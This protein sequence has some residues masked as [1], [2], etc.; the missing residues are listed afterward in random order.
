MIENIKKEKQ[1]F[2]WDVFVKQFIVMA[3][4]LN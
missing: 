1:R 4:S 2:S 3:E